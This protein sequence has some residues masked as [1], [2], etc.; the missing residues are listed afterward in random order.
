MQIK[1]ICALVP[2]ASYV[3]VNDA[4]C[5]HVKSV[6]RHGRPVRNSGDSRGSP[7]TTHQTLYVEFGAPFTL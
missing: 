2:I 7:L 6:K 1:S 4:F 5:I 3:Q